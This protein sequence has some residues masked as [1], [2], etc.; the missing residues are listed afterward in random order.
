MKFEIASC[1]WLPQSVWSVVSTGTCL[2]NNFSLSAATFNFFSPPFVAY[3][4]IHVACNFADRQTDR[5]KD[6]WRTGRQTDKQLNLINWFGQY[7]KWVCYNEYHIKENGG[8]ADRQTDTEKQT[9][10]QLNLINGWTD[11][12]SDGRSNEMGVMWLF[13]LTTDDYVT[14]FFNV[15]C[16]I[17]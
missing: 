5:E 7:L 13:V 15:T 16:H 2:R 10:R 4:I 12:R 3:N 6:G 11:G 14:L 17:K 8:R 9:D 1:L